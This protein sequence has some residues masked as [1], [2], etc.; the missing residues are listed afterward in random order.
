MHKHH[1]VGVWHRLT[2][3]RIPS[4]LSL[5]VSTHSLSRRCQ[6]ASRLCSQYGRV[7]KKGTI[8][9][10]LTVTVY[11]FF[12]S[13]LRALLTKTPGILCAAVVSGASFELTSTSQ[14]GWE[15]AEYP[16]PCGQ[17]TLRECRVATLQYLHG[18]R[19]HR[20]DVPLKQIGDQTVSPSPA[21]SG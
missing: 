9:A 13:P 8:S 15:S 4:R 18:L 2:D 6:R 17:A 12:G 16:L 19:V 3:G 10:S 7:K 14:P 20:L 1:I 11:R 21:L 5:P